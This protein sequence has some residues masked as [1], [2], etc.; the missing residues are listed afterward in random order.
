M[1]GLIDLA[2]AET[3]TAFQLSGILT[4]LRLVHAYRDPEY[5]EPT[6]TAYRIAL[7]DLGGTTDGKLDGVH[8]NRAL[9]GADMVQLFM[10]T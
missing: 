1:R 2:I 8:V 7:G 6:N 5:V 9:Y 4:T 10:S 3:N